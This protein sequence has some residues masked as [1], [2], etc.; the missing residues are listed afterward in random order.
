MESLAPRIAVEVVY[1]TPQ[2][3]FLIKLEVPEETT[4]REAV[5][6]SGLYQRLPNLNATAI[7]LGVFSRIAEE[8]ERVRAGDRIEIYRELLADPKS[9]RRLRAAKAKKDRSGLL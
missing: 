1:A 8:D 7:K 9:T 6:H 4:L 3:Q 2:Q 5:Q